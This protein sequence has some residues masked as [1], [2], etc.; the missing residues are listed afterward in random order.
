MQGVRRIRDVG[1]E[2]EALVPSLWFPGEVLRDGGAGQRVA[3]GEGTC[4]VEDR[5]SRTLE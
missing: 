2:Q 4:W 5:D 3:G 1:E